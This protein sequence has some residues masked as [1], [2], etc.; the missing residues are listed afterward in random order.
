MLCHVQAWWAPELR[1]AVPR[2]V[3]CRL[4]PLAA[5]LQAGAPTTA[6]DVHGDT[7]LHLATTGGHLKCMEALMAWVAGGGKVSQQQRQDG[8]EAAEHQ[9]AEA[10]VEEGDH[11]ESEGGDGEWAGMEARPDLGDPSTCRDEDARGARFMKVLPLPAIDEGLCMIQPD[12]GRHD[13]QSAEREEASL[14]SSSRHVAPDSSWSPT[15]PAEPVAQT[16]HDQPSGYSQDAAAG[17]ELLEASSWWEDSGPSSLNSP[18]AAAG[19]TAAADA[20]VA[21]Y[22]A[23]YE[24][25]EEEQQQAEGWDAWGGWSTCTTE[26]GDVYYYNTLTGES[27]W[28][29]PWAAMGT[30]HWQEAPGAQ[31]TIEGQQQQ[32]EEGGD[33]EVAAERHPSLDGEVTR[34]PV[35]FES[36]VASAA[37]HT[38]RST[39]AW[40]DDAL[41]QDVLTQQEDEDLDNDVNDTWQQDAPREL[42]PAGA[43]HEDEEQEGE[44]KVRR[45][46]AV[47]DRFLSNAM[48]AAESRMHREE[49]DEAQ[50]FE[51]WN[52]RQRKAALAWPQP[53]PDNE[54]EEVMTACRLATHD[55]K[56]REQAAQRLCCARRK[57]AR[58]AHARLVL[59]LA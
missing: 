51:N 8:D 54:L 10:L 4:R 5:L 26:G 3:P 43:G 59:L 6:R 17:S 33:V 2:V 55:G 39:A 37:M 11:G 12:C 28:H 36:P 29:S 19:S 34:S 13:D 23:Q 47:F 58:A 32:E 50:R 52:P 27:Q 53:I 48:L 44:E 31:W 40:D 38:P 21:M 25:E 45:H 14:G 9:R 22:G 30:G 56:R 42:R 57:A 49:E 20:E 7:P 35:R 18:P 16:V 24:G 1:Q 15:P 41:F 46:M